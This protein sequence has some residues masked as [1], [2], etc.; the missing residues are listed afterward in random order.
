MKERLTILSYW[1]SI[2]LTVL[3]LAGNA[4]FAISPL[5]DVTEQR[6]EIFF[7]GIDFTLRLNEIECIKAGFDP[8]DVRSGRVDRPPFYPY[9]ESERIGATYYKPI[10]VYTPWEYT[11]MMPFTW[12]SR[13]VAWTVHIV[14]KFIALGV[15]GWFAFCFAK[16]RL[17]L[18]HPSAV[19]LTSVTLLAITFPT[20][21]DFLNGNFALPIT[22]A[23]LLMVVCLN[24]NH[25]ILAGV[26]WAFAMFKP[27]MALPIAIPLLLKKRYVTVVTAASI[28]VL[29]AVQASALSHTPIV[30]MIL[31]SVFG[32]ACAFNGCGTLPYP[33]LCLFRSVRIPDAVS[34]LTGVAVGAACCVWMT[35][36]LRKSDDWFFL[37]LPAS[38]VA[39]T[40]T[41][42]GGCNFCL[43][44]VACLAVA[45]YALR[46][47]TRR[48]VSLFLLSLFVLS[49]PYSAF[50]FF[51]SYFSGVFSWCQVPKE[52]NLV[53]DSLEKIGVLLVTL[54]AARAWAKSN[55]TQPS[56]MPI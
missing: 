24:R 25:D 6:R 26:L 15:I 2:V 44:A 19:L 11:F 35:G 55:S 27:Q 1:A 54:L 32:G 10:D 47:P 21:V 4:Y 8:H 53:L 39:V 16:A 28:C 23:I 3:A 12:V 36:R 51:T 49:C 50:S 41:Y 45:G 31:N 18:D 5:H 38:G 29:G 42:A 43:D 14:L 48:N 17:K 56:A 40:W 46:S 34:I 30:K 33:V 37:L 9:V 7:H 22:A 52:M 20:W 13:S